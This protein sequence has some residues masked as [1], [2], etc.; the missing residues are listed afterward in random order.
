MSKGSVR[1][2]SIDA[3]IERSSLGTPA[4]R[5]VRQSVSAADREQIIRSAVTGRFVASKAAPKSS[6]RS[7]GTTG[8]G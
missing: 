6:G 7:S 8:A 3:L 5:M 2:A 4:A 1:R